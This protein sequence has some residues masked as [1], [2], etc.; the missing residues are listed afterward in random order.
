MKKLMM[1]IKTAIMV[2]PTKEEKDAMCTIFAG[3]CFV[4]VTP[5]IICLVLG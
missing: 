5:I 1:E 3:L 4:L 2:E